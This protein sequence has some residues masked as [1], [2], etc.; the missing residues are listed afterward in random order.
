MKPIESVILGTEYKAKNFDGI[1]VTL[2]IYPENEPFDGDNPADIAAYQ[3]GDFQMFVA[4]M[5]ASW[6]GISETDV[7]GGI[8]A[9]DLEEV[10]NVAV[11]N[12]MIDSALKAL[13]ERLVSLKGKFA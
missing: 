3:R 13:G 10:E 7:L 12:G 11:D 9:A 1:T 8:A 5:V 4:E 2:N 6:N